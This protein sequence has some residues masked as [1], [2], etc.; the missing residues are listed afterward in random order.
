MNK[1]Q[2]IYHTFYHLIYIQSNNK[3]KVTTMQKE[4]KF[5]EIQM[6]KKEK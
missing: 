1:K 2:D 3:Y 6:V 5:I 4:I